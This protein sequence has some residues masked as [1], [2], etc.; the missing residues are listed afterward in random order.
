MIVYLFIFVVLALIA[1]AMEANLTKNARIAF[2][3]IGY[4]VILLYVGLRWETGNDWSPYYNY[5]N[6]LSSIHD[7]SDEFELGY[8]VLSILAKSVC[9]PYGGFLFIYS[10][11]Y[12][13]LI[14]ISFKGENHKIS[15]WMILL[16]YCSFL[17]GWMGTARQVMAIGICLISVRYVLARKRI[18]FL[19]CIALASCFHASALSFLLAWPL[20]Q[21]KFKMRYAVIAVILLAAM[22]YTSVGTAS[23]AFVLEHSPWLLDKIIYYAPIT[24]TDLDL[25]GGDLAFLWYLKR[26]LSLA[27][28]VLFRK[29]FVSGA[30]K[31]YLKLYAVSV[32]MFV[33]F[34]KSIAMIPLRMGLYFS[35]FELFLLASLTQ[36]I[37]TPALQKI[38]CAFL[39]VV[40]FSRLYSSLYLYHPEM[41]LP[42]KTQFFNEDVFRPL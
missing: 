20:A 40:A 3:C 33:V 32:V 21:L 12:L 29:M 11:I 38:Y 31:L 22:L 10:A 7:N 27:T 24:T 6:S 39:V 26:I 25:S 18:K 13:A 30:E 1:F 5:Y 37:K 42:Y 41:F 36:R 16:F 8:R 17:L 14:V 2:I 9:L 28:F 15:G 19:L 34:F 4:C 35:V 23:M